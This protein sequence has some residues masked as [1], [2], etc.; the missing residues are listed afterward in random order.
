MIAG[1]TTEM[2][3]TFSVLSTRRNHNNIN[4]CFWCVLLWGECNTYPEL[5]Q[6][7][8]STVCKVFKPPKKAHIIM[9]YL[10][11]HWMMC[12][13]IKAL[14]KLKG[15][16]TSTVG[17]AIS[18]CIQEAPSLITW[19]MV[20]TLKWMIPDSLMMM[21]IPLLYSD[22]MWTVGS[23]IRKFWCDVCYDP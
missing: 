12:I 14:I 1:G 20:T 9:K 5:K 7:V 11:Y 17:G 8:L 2:C 4:Y 19:Q 22:W 13:A 10:I 18:A 23:Y 3:V 15:E 6:N 21:N 16:P